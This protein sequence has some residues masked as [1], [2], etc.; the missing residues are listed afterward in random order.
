MTKKNAYCWLQDIFSMN[1]E[2]AHIGQ[3]SDYMC[4]Q[5]IIESKRVLE[6]HQIA[7]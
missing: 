6:N 4:E 1:D 3:F 7:C 2:Q 5:V